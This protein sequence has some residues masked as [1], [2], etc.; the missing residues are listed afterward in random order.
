MLTGT[1]ITINELNEITK[2][3]GENNSLSTIIFVCVDVDSNDCVVLQI[4]INEL[5]HVL[6][7]EFQDR[8]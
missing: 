4:T 8:P 3:I 6:R 5:T 1:K 2:I 7:S